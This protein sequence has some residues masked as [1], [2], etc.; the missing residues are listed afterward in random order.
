MNWLS[1]SKIAKNKLFSSFFD[2]IS[3]L[4]LMYAKKKFLE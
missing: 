2:N 1:K 4:I 3:D